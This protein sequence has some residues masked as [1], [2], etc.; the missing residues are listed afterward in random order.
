[1]DFTELPTNIA[2]EAASAP[3]RRIREGRSTTR[4]AKLLARM[5]VPGPASTTKLIRLWR[6][7]PDRRFRRSSRSG[8]DASRRRTCWYDFFDGGNFQSGDANLSDDFLEHRGCASPS[9]GLTRDVMHA[10]NQPAVTPPRFFDHRRNTAPGIKPVVDAV[11][12]QA[13]EI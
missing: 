4:R 9:G 10:E 1:M 13:S 5:A 6:C 7:L 2:A 11:C 8:S 3:R 12:A